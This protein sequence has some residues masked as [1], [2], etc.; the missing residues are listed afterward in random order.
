MNKNKS[1]NQD[2]DSLLKEVLKDDLHPE[3]ENRMKR[4]FIQF[5]EKIEQQKR[6]SR[7]KTGMIGR[8]L[9]RQETWRWAHWMLRKEILAFLS[10]IMI[11]LGGFMHL[12][13]HSSA[14]AESLSMLRTSV[15]VFEQIRHVASMKCTVQ[16]PAHNGK[17]LA[18]SIQWIS[19][20]MTRVDVR[21]ADTINK[22]LWMLDE[23]FIIADRKKNTLHKAG[24]FV[25]I[26][27][28]VFQP[29][30]GFLS[31]EELAERIYRSWQPVQYKK[32]SECGQGT[33]AFTNHEE[34][35]LLEMTID[36]NTYLPVKISKFFQDSIKAGEEKKQ[37]LEVHFTWNQPISPKLM[38]PEITKRS[39]GS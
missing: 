6:K 21:S 17:S 3:A 9:L 25:Q 8:R 26:K 10:I 18:Y 1:N 29:V 2:I 28:S 14:L 27:D 24:S 33:F 22:T 36:L 15:S 16:V 19:P 30:I 34:K 38:V 35:A 39:Q 31:P 12:S 5:R 11:A 4:Q 37:A 7:M 13:G 32:Q 20:N 23:H